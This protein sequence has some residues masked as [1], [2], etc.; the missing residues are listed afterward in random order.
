[1]P[2]FEDLKVFTG[3][4]HPQLARDICSYLGIDLGSCEVFKFSNDNTFVRI[5]ENIRERDVFLVQ[6]ISAPVN[7]HLMELWIMIDAARRA[8]AGRITAVIPYYAYGRTDKKD[9]PRVA[10]T[11]RLIA[12]FTSVAGA[13]RVLTVDLH[14]GQIQAFS[15]SLWMS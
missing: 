1:M 15:A 11:A 4:A 2:L 10:I 8:S 14:A 12:D 6:P 5:L 3:N 9:Q 7:E 13:N